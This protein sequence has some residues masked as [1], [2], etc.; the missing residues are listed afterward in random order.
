MINIGGQKTAKYMW[1]HLLNRQSPT[2][3]EVHPKTMYVTY[4]KFMGAHFT[5]GKRAHLF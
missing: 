3:T 2:T 1:H 4:Q 5:K